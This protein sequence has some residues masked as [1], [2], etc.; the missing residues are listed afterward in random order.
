MLCLP[1]AVQR[2]RHKF[3]VRFPFTCCCMQ[4]NSVS[5]VPK[6][7]IREV[8]LS[9]C[10]RGGVRKRPVSSR[11]LTCVGRVILGVSVIY[12]LHCGCGYSS[13]MHQTSSENEI[14]N[15]LTAQECTSTQNSIAPRKVPRRAEASSTHR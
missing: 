5:K 13:F 14:Q 3:I 8:G 11:Q 12:D 2:T 6:L 10:S 1:V 7:A 9:R 15:R 4:E